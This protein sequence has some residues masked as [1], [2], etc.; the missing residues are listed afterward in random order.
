MNFSSADDVI[1][2]YAGR[3]APAITVQVRRS[4]KVVYERAQGWLD[5]ETRQRP[6][7]MDTQFDLASVTKLFV[8]TAFMLQVESGRRKLDEAVSRT[9]PEFAGLRP[10]QAYEHPLQPGQFVQPAPGAAEMVDAGKVTYRHLLTHSAGLPAWR[11]L[12]DQPDAGAALRM[13]LNTAFYYPTGTRTIYSD[14]GL[15]LLGLA[16][17]RTLR[18]RLDEQVYD[19]VTWPL[20]LLHTRYLPLAGQPYDTRNIAPTEVCAW[21][22]RRVVGEVHDEN[23]ARLGGIAGHAGLFSTAGDLAQFG[24]AFLNTWQP[25]LKPATVAEMARLQAQE[26]TTRRGLGF[27][28]WCDDPQASGNPFSPSAFGHTGFTGTSLWMDPERKLVVAVLTN[29]VYYGRDAGEII[30]FRSDLHRAIVAEVDRNA[31]SAR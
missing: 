16:V 4:G 24:Q 2:A 17:E 23:A 6:V 25:L 1:A 29:R 10:V 20:R 18:R 15:I 31:Y 14:I 11:P 26:G 8:A 19:F 12:K 13:A 22:G 7:Q 27:A 28:L 3:V 9:I 30:Q 5:P 21:R